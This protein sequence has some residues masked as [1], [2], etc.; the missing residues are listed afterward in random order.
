MGGTAMFALLALAGDI[1]CMT[2][3]SIVGVVSD[4]LNGNLQMGIFSA[5][6]FPTLMLLCL[7]FVRK[8]RQ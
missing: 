2:G 3:P 8:K 1:G 7:L 5:I 4:G 6:L